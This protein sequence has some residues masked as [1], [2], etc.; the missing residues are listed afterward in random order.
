MN[1]QDILKEDSLDKA[2]KEYKKLLLEKQAM[3]SLGM[4]TVNEMAKVQ[5]LNDQLD[6]LYDKILHMKEDAKRGESLDSDFGDEF[7]EDNA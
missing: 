4:L 6:E 2:V 5:K 7:S 3:L 1:W